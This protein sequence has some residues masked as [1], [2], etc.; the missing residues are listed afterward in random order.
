MA[1]DI[2]MERV[3]LSYPH[4]VTPWAGRQGND[5]KYNC[6][7]ILPQDFAQWP[8]VQECVNNAILNKFG[9]TPPDN[10]KL[11]WLNKFLQPSIVKG[12]PYNGLYTFN[13]NADTA[14]KPE[15]LDQNVQPMSDMVA[16]SALFGGC[17][18]NGYVNF[19][20]YNNAGNVGVGVG[21]RK[22]QLVDNQNVIRLGEGDKPAEEVFKAVPGAPPPTAQ[23]PGGPAA[24]TGQVPHRMP[25]E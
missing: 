3:I 1:T 19:Y 6:A 25:W 12:G 11:P 8:Q 5:P 23:V 13:A 17:I 22:I 20:G 9:A 15:L 16:K 18:V 2:V 24:P 10:L 21:L 14:R 4:L 7:F